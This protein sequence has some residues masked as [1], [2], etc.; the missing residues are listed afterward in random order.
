MNQR[1]SIQKKNSEWRKVAKY[2]GKKK[3]EI[4]APNLQWGVTFGK[5][6]KE[7]KAWEG[8]F[9]HIMDVLIF[10]FL[11]I[12]FNYFYYNYYLKKGQNVHIS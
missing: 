3:L 12:L 11:V 4:Q 9:G 2:R 1:K 6:G 7:I 8:V 5:E 10:F